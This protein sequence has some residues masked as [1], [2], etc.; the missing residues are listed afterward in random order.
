MHD[1]RPHQAFTAAALT[2]LFGALP[3]SFL[4]Y[5]A[6]VAIY[7]GAGII[8]DGSIAPGSFLVLWGGAG[9]YGTISLWFAAF[10]KFSRPVIAG[11]IFGLLAIFPF[12]V[13]AIEDFGTLDDGVDQLLLASCIGPSIVASVLLVRLATKHE[14]AYNNES[15]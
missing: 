13:G 14:P 9:I 10:Q 11:L 3:A 15:S 8:T 12:T 5:V 6:L 2:I 7:F 1:G 4:S